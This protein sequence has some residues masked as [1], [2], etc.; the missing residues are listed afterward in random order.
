M[1]V[2]WSSDYC[3]MDDIGNGAG[4]RQHCD[5]LVQKSP[6]GKAGA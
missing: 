3:A 4:L 5:W 2:K 1:V 6:G